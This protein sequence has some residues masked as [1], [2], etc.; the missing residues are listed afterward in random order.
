[1]PRIV[2]QPRATDVSL[3][4]SRT[5]LSSHPVRERRLLSGRRSDDDVV[6]AGDGIYGRVDP[7]FLGALPLPCFRDAAR[8]RGSFLSQRGSHRRRDPRAEKREARGPG[9]GLLLQL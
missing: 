3:C 2:T 9:F 7:D 1:G 6:I 8:R 4:F 5:L